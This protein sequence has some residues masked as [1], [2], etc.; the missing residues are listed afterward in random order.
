MKKIFCIICFLTIVMALSACDSDDDSD[1]TGGS[2]SEDVSWN[3]FTDDDAVTCYN[4]DKNVIYNP[5][6]Y[7]EWLCADYNGHVQHVKAKFMYDGT[8]HTLE[9][10]ETWPCSK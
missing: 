5:Y 4:A 6:Q 9:E 3:L 8:D 7:C 10:V 1:S 2:G